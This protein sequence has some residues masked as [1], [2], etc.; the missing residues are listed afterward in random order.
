MA[1]SKRGL[2]IPPEILTDGQLGST[3]KMVYAAMAEAAE[4]DGFIRITAKELGERLGITRNAAVHSR[5]ILQKL[6]YV[7]RID[8]T[9]YNYRIIRWPGGFHG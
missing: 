8:R 7:R 3:Q 9:S 2:Y 4:D 1:G 5:N 6:G